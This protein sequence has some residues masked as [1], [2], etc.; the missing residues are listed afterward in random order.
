MIRIE[1]L[2]Y[3][4]GFELLDYPLLDLSTNGWVYKCDGKFAC[5]NPKHRY[6]PNCYC[7]IRYKWGNKYFNKLSDAIE[8]MILYVA[9]LCHKI[10]EENE[11]KLKVRSAKRFLRNAE[12]GIIFRQTGKS[13]YEN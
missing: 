1:I 12:K 6:Y 8:A 9:K 5:N 3:N 13:I 7:E 2:R 4:I 10:I 11:D